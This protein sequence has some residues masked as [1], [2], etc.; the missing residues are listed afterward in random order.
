[1]DTREHDER[2]WGAYTVLEDAADH[3]VK[4]ITVLPGKRLSYQRHAKRS[5][6][7][8]VVRGEGVVVLDGEE[9]RIGPASA[10][11]VPVGVA[12]R[13]ANTGEAELVFIEVQHGSYF[14]EDD[15]VRIEDDFGRSG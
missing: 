7:W 8:F 12:H 10:I 1:M 13:I 9:K 11:D 15:I 5:E 4:E 2:P 14:G 6:H 3:K